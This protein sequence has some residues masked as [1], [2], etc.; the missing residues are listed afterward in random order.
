MGWKPGQGIGPKITYRQLQQQNAQRNAQ[1]GWSVTELPKED[2]DEEAKK[3]MY[4][5]RDTPLI[6]YQ[7][8]ENSFGIGY[9]PGARLP[10]SDAQQTL[11]QAS[12]PKLSG[13][14]PVS[15]SIFMLSN[16]FPTAGFGLGALN[17]AEDDDIDV[18]DHTHV[19]PERRHLAYD[20]IEADNSNDSFTMGRKATS[21]VTKPAPRMQLETFQSG[22]PVLPGF[23]KTAQPAVQD[24]W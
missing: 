8:K 9:V 19:N 6:A 17:D 5:P 10:G 11:K 3:H 15:C 16:N 2:G 24:V 23:R 22:I 20:E 7:K 18:Y 13:L 12:G 14:P 1:M 4:P 21:R